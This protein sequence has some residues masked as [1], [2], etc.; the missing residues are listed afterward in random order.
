MSTFYLNVW[1][2]PS[3]R[4]FTGGAMMSDRDSCLKVCSDNRAVAMERA[5]PLLVNKRVCIL[6]VTLK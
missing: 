2:T 1:E 3:G 4:R 6:K 5:S